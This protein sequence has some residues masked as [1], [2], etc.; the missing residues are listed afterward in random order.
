MVELSLIKLEGMPS[1]NE[2]VFLHHASKSLIVTDMCFNI[3]KPEGLGA[4]IIFGLFGTYDRFAVSRLFK[5]MI[6]DKAALKKSIDEVLSCDFD[7]IIVSHG[8]NII[9]GAN[10]K[11][12]AALAE[13]GF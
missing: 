1:Y 3:R 6:K 13:R 5:M 2:V 9:G 11:L 12:R 7:N 4:K 8:E 10:E